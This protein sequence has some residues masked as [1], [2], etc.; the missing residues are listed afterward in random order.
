MGMGMGNG[1][2]FVSE[3]GEGMGIAEGREMSGFDGSGT[4][5]RDRARR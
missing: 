5:G 2:G 3:L 1:N 4:E